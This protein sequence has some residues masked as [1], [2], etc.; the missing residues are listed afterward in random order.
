MNAE[1]E[2][3]KESFSCRCKLRKTLGYVS[4]LQEGTIL[5]YAQETPTG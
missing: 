2:Q 5:Q 4:K 3:A 1:A